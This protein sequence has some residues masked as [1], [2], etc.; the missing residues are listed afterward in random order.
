IA[1]EA[2]FFGAN[3]AAIVL[4]NY[5]VCP[6]AVMAIVMWAI[7]RYNVMMI[8]AEKHVYPIEDGQNKEK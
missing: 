5:I 3:T 2:M 8:Y 4:K 1:A 7:I 6:I